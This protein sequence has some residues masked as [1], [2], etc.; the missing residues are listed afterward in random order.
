MVVVAVVAAVLFGSVLYT[1]LWSLDFLPS[2]SLHT[3]VSQ[4][5]GDY[6]SPARKR[7]RY[8]LEHLYYLLAKIIL[9]QQHSQN[10]NNTEKWK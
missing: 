3:T 2:N 9:W 6:L 7:K 1:Q 4:S 8:K 10:R 5:V